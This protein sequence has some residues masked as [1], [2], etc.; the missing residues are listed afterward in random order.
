M[1]A[2]TRKLATRLARL[3]NKIDS[4]LD[5]HLEGADADR[6]FDAGEFSGPAHWRGH[7][8]DADQLA[9]QYGFSSVDVAD[10]AAG[11][12]GMGRMFSSAV[13]GY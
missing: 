1:N 12:L 7:K 6:G 10:Q 3:A 4:N 9:R 2:Q 5:E 8:R 13:E 11:V